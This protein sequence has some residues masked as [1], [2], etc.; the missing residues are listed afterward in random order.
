M[1]SGAT[2]PCLD[3]LQE[4]LNPDNGNSHF[5]SLI[6]KDTNFMSHLISNGTVRV[7]ITIELT[8]HLY[9]R[10]ERDEL[11]FKSPKEVEWA[12]EILGY[13]FIPPEYVY[14]REDRNFLKNILTIYEYILC[15]DVELI[16]D[17]RKIRCVC[18][19]VYFE[20]RNN[21]LACFEKH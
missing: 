3:A 9:D 13:G 19:K 21:I 18:L 10:I 7:N 4:L 14:V 15:E 16:I 2:L 17:N 1:Q 11:Q 8:K 5:V 20:E 12:L 6:E